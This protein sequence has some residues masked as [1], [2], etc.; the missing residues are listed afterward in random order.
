MRGIVF[1]VLALFLFSSA[2]DAVAAAKKDYKKTSDCSKVRT[3]VYATIV[4]HFC[5]TFLCGIFIRKLMQV[6]HISTVLM[7][8]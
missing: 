5:N 2:N 6:A 4:M 1:A 3:N 8:K 7:Q